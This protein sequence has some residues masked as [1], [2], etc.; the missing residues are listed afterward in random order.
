MDK[1]TSFCAENISD[2]LLRTSKKFPARIAYRIRRGKDFE[3]FLWQDVFSYVKKFAYY[4]QASGIKKGDKIAILGEN[5]PEW[6]ISYLAVHWAGGVTIPL[7]SRAHSNEWAH[8]LRHSESKVIFVSK[9]FLPDIE[10]IK[11][12]V[13]QLKEIMTPDR[14]IR[15]DEIKKINEYPEKTNPAEI[16]RDDIAVIL[17]TSGTTG[18]SKGVMLTNGNIISNIEGCMDMMSFTPEDRFFSVLPIHHVFEATTGFLVPLTNGCSVTF[19]RSLRSNEM[20]EDMLDTRPNFMLVVPLILEKLLSGINKK[21]KSAPISKKI[22]LSVLKKT[23]RVFN[24]V[25]DGG[26]S[27]KLFKKLQSAL[28]LDN[29]KYLLSGGSALPKYISEEYELLGFPILQGYGLSETS[30]VVSVN[31]AK[32]PKN[33]SVGLPLKNVKVKIMEPSP[34]GIGEIAVIGP[35][36]MKGYYKNETA[37]KEVF[38]EDGWFLTGDLGKIDSEGYIYITGRKKSVIVTKGGE[39]IYPEELEEKLLAS[40]FIGEVLVMAKLHPETKTEI[41]HAEVYPDYEYLDIYAK[42]KGLEISDKN[43]NKIIGDEIKKINNELTSYKRVSSF[44]IRDEEFP[45]TT[46]RKIKRYLFESGGIEIKKP[47]GC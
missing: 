3:I 31:P 7:D 18:A 26:A 39:N 13:P 33:E 14:I 27:K 24:P 36:V 46:T 35:T 16:K 28:G 34:D 11:E 5:S 38:T 40:P 17:Y 43:L 4:L 12:N 8:I 2:L 44:T 47:A 25:T 21:I 37:T 6:C 15:G 42:E 20:I 19:S 29:L 41:L 1:E 45:K 30:P 22:L 10:D 9:K 23:A 32:K